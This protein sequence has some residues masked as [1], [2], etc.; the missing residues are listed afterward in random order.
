MIESKL[1]STIASS[2]EAFDKLLPYL[3][4]FQFSEFGTIVANLIFEFY[5]S[6]PTATAV[7][8]D[9]IKPILVKELPKKEAYINEF[10]SVLPP[11]AS[12]PNCVK[13][14]E[15]A[16]K[17]KLGLGVMQA[18]SS[19]Q[20][21]RA[22]EL[23]EEYLT[24]SVDDIQEE[25]IFNATSIEDLD[26]HF[27]GKN[28]IPIYPTGLN[29]LLGGGVPRQSQLCIFARPDVGKSVAAINLACGAAETGHRVLYVGN[30]DPAPKMMYRILT[31]FTRQP[32]HVIKAAPKKWFDEAIS[33]G[34]S[35]LFF[36]P[37]HPGTIS[38]I[39][40]LIE[41]L[42]PDLVV[43]DQMRNLVVNKSNMV[44]NLDE[45]CRATRNL[46]KEF[47]LVMVTVTQAGDS[48][49]NKPWLDYTDVDWSNT[50]VAAAMDLMI[51]LGQ[52]K[53]MR[54]RNQVILNFP[55]NKLTAPLKPIT[56]TI[57]YECNRI[58]I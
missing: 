9:L 12:V 41:K 6:D 8:W 1:L 56:A 40:G 52:T 44:L 16:K 36:V 11:P 22:K 54:D 3:D 30:E 38:E 5:E 58:L 42:Q 57:D 17:E 23:M 33:K 53:D 26:Y 45:V 55:K 27:T 18:L 49:T 35:N 28:L 19:N 21:S 46:A 51:G 10:I 43:I 50:G 7:D 13:L 15:T 25:E 2:R 34:Y 14:Y 31:R 37:K 47:N 4:E 39:R 29:D 32:T 48:A 24:L 20:E